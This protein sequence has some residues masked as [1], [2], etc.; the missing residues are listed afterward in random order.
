MI[1]SKL[2]DEYGDYALDHIRNFNAI[3]C[4]FEDSKGKL[5]DSTA[6]WAMAQMLNLTNLIDYTEEDKDQ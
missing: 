1:R 6:C 5:Y 4:M 3:P 2:L